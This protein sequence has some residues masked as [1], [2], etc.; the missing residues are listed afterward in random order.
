MTEIAKKIILIFLVFIASDIYSLTVN[1]ADFGWN[2]TDATEALQKAIN[3]GVDTVLVPKMKSDWIVRPIFARSDSQTIIFERGVVLMA[4]E[5]EFKDIHDG[6]FT[7]G[8][9]YSKAADTTLK[10]GVK[11]V[12]LVGYGAFFRMRKKDYRDST[13]YIKSEWRHCLTI[14]AVADKPV[15]HIKVF[16]I[17]MDSSGG[18]GMIVSGRAYSGKL[19]WQPENVLVRDV[20]CNDNHRQGISPTS[21]INVT[22]EDCVLE[23]TRGTAPQAGV[24]WEPDWQRL[25]NGKMINCLMLDNNM[26]GIDIYLMKKS[27]PPDIS[28]SFFYCHSA[29]SWDTTIWSQP[30]GTTIAAIFDNGPPTTISFTG[31]SFST[32][33][34]HSLVIQNVSSLLANI[35]FTDCIFDRKRMYKY[36]PIE[37]RTSDTTRMV[38]S[39]GLTFENCVLN[40][41]RNMP[42]IRF[43]DGGKTGK[44]I[45]DLSGTITVNNPYQ[46]GMNLGADTSNITLKVM[47][48]KTRAP[49]VRVA[50]PNHL[51]EITAP[52][53]VNFS[54]TAWDADV[55]TL[56]GKGIKQVVFLIRKGMTV[57][58]SLV[59][60]IAPYQG[61]IATTGLKQG[62]YSIWAKAVSQ[63]FGSIA[64]DV[65]AFRLVTDE[66]APLF[67]RGCTDSTYLGF[68]PEAIISVVESCGEKIMRGCMTKGFVEYDSLANV[69]DTAICK[70][71]GIELIDISEGLRINR[72]NRTL[73]ISLNGEYEIACYDIQ[74]IS[75]FAAQGAGTHRYSLKGL[76]GN[77]VY[78]LRW[79][80]Q[81]RE[82][83]KKFILE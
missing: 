21:G 43:I 16:G 3:S 71:V 13:K 51:A 39:G 15:E 66:Y 14:R 5:G 50:L 31:C 52:A 26:H 28:L 70:T 83:Q 67:T 17:Q 8:T 81:G 11:N 82:V 48:N 20:V 35:Q 2:A 45:R 30:M 24:D 46:A 32:Q 60:S 79:K 23:G 69:Q 63:E 9:S 7:I 40:F 18:D 77:A 61:S 19:P 37:I 12:T 4:K 33:L 55:D 58:D 75:R 76:K 53:K 44:G 34:R 38:S 10:C 57:I 59:D 25:V 64:V 27:R 1:A 65:Q 42:F 49:Y 47:H 22:F 6:L 72:A 68:D 54:A 80:H 36:Y 62:I 78:I 74:G 56:N 29:S 73:V 41:E